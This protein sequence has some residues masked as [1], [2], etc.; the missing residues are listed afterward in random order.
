MD[1]QGGRVKFKMSTGLL[2]HVFLCDMR[3]GCNVMTQLVVELITTVDL[4]T[5][6]VDVVHLYLPPSAL[7]MTI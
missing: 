1:V 6:N 3:C 2:M 7:E 5:S 4:L